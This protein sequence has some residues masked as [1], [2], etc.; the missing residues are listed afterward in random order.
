MLKRIGIIFLVL[1]LF[2]V[3]GCSSKAVSTGTATQPAGIYKTRQAEIAKAWIVRQIE[4]NLDSATSI[5]L[6]LQPG[7]EVDGY[8]YLEKGNDVDFQISGR[9]V[10]Y[11]STPAT[12]GS[13]N[14][15]SDRFSFI[16]TEEQGIA[17]TLK[18]SPVDTKET[19]KV[20][21]AIFLELIYP[22]SGEI[23]TPMDT[24]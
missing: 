5:L 1:A 12:A 2:T 7:S 15:T 9:S 18:F 14:I 13:A 10:I 16:A 22:G 17:Y 3:L 6:T 20:I 4:I 23:F 11:E 19:K 8:F 21:P 24:K